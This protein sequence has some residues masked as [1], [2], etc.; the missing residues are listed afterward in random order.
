VQPQVAP[1]EALPEAP[2]EMQT[3]DVAEDLGISPRAQTFSDSEAPPCTPRLPRTSALAPVAPS[4][5]PAQPEEEAELR[6]LL[7]T[8]V[9]PKALWRWPE[10]ETSEH[11]QAV[12]QAQ[13]EASHPQPEETVV[14]PLQPEAAQH[15][16]V[17]LDELPDAPRE[18]AQPQ[19]DSLEELPEAPREAPQRPEAAPAQPEKC[20]PRVEAPRTSPKPGSWPLWAL[21]SLGAAAA[22]LARTGT[23]QLMTGLS[24]GPGP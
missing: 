8:P 19:E 22:G 10:F 13:P 14:P 17:P 20:Q 2:Q 1:P 9:W 16:E 5:R 23:P 7:E 12:P 3:F 15:Q 4:R 18:A 6:P 21:A 24:V 11:E